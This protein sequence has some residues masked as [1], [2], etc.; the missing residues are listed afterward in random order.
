MRPE[1]EAKLHQLEES[2][3]SK[4]RVLVAL[5]GGVDSTLLMEIAHRTLG[6]DNA[7]GVTAKSETLTAQEFEAV[8][9]LARARGWNHRIIEYSELEIPNYAANPVNRC[10]FCKSELFSRLKKLADEL[11]CCAVVEGTNA[12]DLGDYRPG[13]QAARELGTWSPLL[14]CQVTKAEV[15]E[16][17]KHFELPTWNKP[18]GACLSSRF[19]YGTPITRE[20]LD[21][22]ALAEEFLKGLGFTQVR[23]R[24]HGPVARIELLPQEMSRLFDNG[25]A[26]TVAEHLRRLGFAFAAL[27]LLGYRTG[28]LNTMLEHEGQ[29]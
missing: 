26:A 13:M 22:V 3:R 11:G 7:I 5:S 18:S 9:E 23:V 17:A 20:K 16:L 29:R 6:H 12:D 14:E 1:L 4:G 19:P 25:L 27:D 15:R 21:Q 10:Y 2:F 28:S 24:H 8:C